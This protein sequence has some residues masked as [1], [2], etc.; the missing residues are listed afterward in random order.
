MRV[1]R[2]ITQTLRLEM[3]ELGEIDMVS[4]ALATLDLLAHDGKALV[5]CAGDRD[6]ATVLAYLTALRLG[7]AG[8]LSG[9]LVAIQ[10]GDGTCPALFL[11][12]PGIG[13]ADQ[14]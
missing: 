3:K 4:M 13:Q 9:M 11:I 8:R 2:D 14:R 7:H 10:D 5:V 12:H 6:L 1:G